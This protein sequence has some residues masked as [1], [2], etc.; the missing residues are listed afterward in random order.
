MRTRLVGPVAGLALLSLCACGG[1]DAHEASKPPGGS[2]V[3]V[4]FGPG[5]SSASPH[6]SG[7]GT[8]AASTSSNGASTSGTGAGSTATT[9]EDAGN[10]EA[11]A[12]AQGAPDAA[13][14]GA[15]S[16]PGDPLA[17]ARAECVMLINM[18]RATLSPPS[19]ALTQAPES[20]ETCVDGQA[21]ADFTANTPHSAFGNC[22][23]DAQDECPGWP[24]PPSAID[25]G[26]LAQMWAE[27]PPPAGQDNHWLNMENPQS[28]Q[29]ACG[30]YQDPDGSWWATQDFW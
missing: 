9:G 13:D 6:G 18:Y 3:V 23:E 12:G 17:A 8:A 11:D 5:A 21:K 1:G 30:F 28:T 2:T 14:T 25:T 20:S 24:G 29:V 26:C 19:P 4:P 10:G 16:D 7:T 15:G 27:G 22:G